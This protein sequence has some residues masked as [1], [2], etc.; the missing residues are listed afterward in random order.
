MRFPL[1][2][3]RGAF[4]L[5]A[6]VPALLLAFAAIPACGQGPGAGGATRFGISVGGI[7]TVGILIEFVDDAHSFEIALGTWSFRDLSVS[8][9]AKQYF[10]AGAAQPFVGGGLWAVIASPADERTGLALV[11]R[12]PIGVDWGFADDHSIG[13]AL[14]VNVGLAVRRTDPDDDMPMNRRLVPLP[15][16]YYRYT[17]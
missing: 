14:S 3:R 2:A 15:E 7:S 13:G 5:H 11:L 4:A 8:V 16:F 12:A 6:C 17:R 9:V 1:P 10:G